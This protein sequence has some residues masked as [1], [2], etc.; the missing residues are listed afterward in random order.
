MAFQSNCTATSDD[1]VALEEVVQLS[2]IGE[3]MKNTLKLMQ[4][5]WQGLRF[6]QLQ[7]IVVA[8]G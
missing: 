1:R 2:R 6:R 7:N 5:C 4:G 3:M 8:K